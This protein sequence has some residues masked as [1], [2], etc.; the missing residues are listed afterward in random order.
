MQNTDLEDFS[1]SRMILNFSCSVTRF[2]ASLSQHIL[3]SILCQ[4][5]THRGFFITVKEKPQMLQRL[6]LLW[7]WTCPAPAVDTG[8]SL[9]W[10]SLAVGISPFFSYLGC[11]CQVPA[12]PP[13]SHSAGWGSWAGKGSSAILVWL[14][15]A[16]RRATSTMPT[17]IAAFGKEQ[18]QEPQPKHC[19]ALGTTQLCVAPEP[20]RTRTVFH[21]TGKWT[22]GCVSEMKCSLF[23]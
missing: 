4:C 14:P 19:F 21:W 22:L 17:W 1:L 15:S 9:L 18:T 2:Y 8:I 10:Q 11:W 23:G 6:P 12:V 13:C 16:A 3:L 7:V 5:A 20:N